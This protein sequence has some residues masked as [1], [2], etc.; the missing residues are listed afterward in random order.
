MH[1]LTPVVLRANQ[2][3]GKRNQEVDRAKKKENNEILTKLQIMGILIFFTLL[4]IY[5]MYR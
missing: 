5:E 1:I 3:E 2:V 4:N